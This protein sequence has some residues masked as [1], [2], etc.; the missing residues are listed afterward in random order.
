MALVLRSLGRNISTRYYRGLSTTGY[1]SIGSFHSENLAE[2]MAQPASDYKPPSLPFY[3]SAPSP[4]FTL[5]LENWTFLNHGAFGGPLQVGMDRARAWRDFI[6]QQPLRAMD[7]YLLPHLA[8]SAR[9]LAQFMQVPT[10]DVAILENVTEGMNIV[11]A[12]HAR[13]HG[14]DARIVLWDVGYGSVKK[15]ARHYY[16]D[17]VH[18]LQLLPHLSRLQKADNIDQELGQIMIEQWP[19]VEGAATLFVLDHTTSNT[20]LT[21]PVQ[22]LASVAK[23]LCPGLTTVVDG[24][25]GLLAQPIDYHFDWT[26]IDIYVGNAHKW[27]S[28]PRGAAILYAKPPVH[29]L[30]Q[31]VVVSHGVDEPDLLSRLVWNGSRDYAAALAVPAVLD[32]WQAAGPDKVRRQVKKQLE[33]GIAILAD[34]WHPEAVTA[35][36]WPGRVTLVDF[37]SGWLSPMALVQ[38]PEAFGENQTSTVAKNVQ[39]FLYENQIE[40]P[41]KC[42]DGRLFVRLSCHVYTTDHDFEVLGETMEALTLALE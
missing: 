7:R 34:T 15:M 2:L 1:Q 38:L 18:V 32:Y 11:L 33:Q 19:E 40:V 5:D 13:R 42:I 29:D 30:L 17:K 24:A 28:S 31:P 3:P 27:L 14:T 25:H 41:I 36:D 39:D 37:A 16:D 4:G 22:R 12:S 23:R 9:R 6:E 21:L 26:D 8:Y 35:E 10:T 20:A